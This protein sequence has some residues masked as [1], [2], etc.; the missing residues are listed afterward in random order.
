M[1]DSLKLAPGYVMVAATMAAPR[2]SREL[3]SRCSCT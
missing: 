3:V 2:E 1:D